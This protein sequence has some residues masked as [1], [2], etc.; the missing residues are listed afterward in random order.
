MNPYRSSPVSEGRRL[1]PES[2]AL[3]A[4]YTTHSTVRRL[5]A[6]RNPYHLR[7]LVTL[8]PTHDD[9]DPYPAWLA[10]CDSWARELQLCTGYPVR[11]ERLDE[12]ILDGVMIDAEGAIV[13]TLSWRDPTCT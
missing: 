5:W 6:F 10:N 1:D 3:A 7:I 8:E 4:W 2:A 13:T 12:P 9:S 11:L